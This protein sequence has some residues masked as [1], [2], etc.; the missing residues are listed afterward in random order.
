MNVM[1]TSLMINTNVSSG[2][3]FSLLEIVQAYPL[4][5][6][7]LGHLSALYLLYLLF[8]RY[9][10]CYHKTIYHLL[11]QCLQ[12]KPYWNPL[13]ISF[14]SSLGSTLLLIERTTI[15]PLY[16]WVIKDHGACSSWVLGRPRRLMVFGAQSLWCKAPGK[17]RGLQLGCGDHPEHLTGS[18]DR[19]QGLLFVWVRW[20]PS[21]VL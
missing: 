13:V 7:W 8:A 1:K 11:F 5:H 3:P 4:L 16:L 10:L 21:R 18:G 2:A 12:R 20:P 9:Y 19:P 6:K 15:D 17:H 14:C